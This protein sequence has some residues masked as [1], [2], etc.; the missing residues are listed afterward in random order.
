MAAA[1]RRS[2]QS[3][4]FRHLHQ[5]ARAAMTKHRRRLGTNSRSAFQCARL[6]PETRL[7]QGRF[8]PGP[9]GL[10]CPSP[11]PHMA[12]PPCPI[13]SSYKDTRQHWLGAHPTELILTECSRSEVLGVRASACGFGG[14][15]TTPTLATETPTRHQPSPRSPLPPPRDLC[16]LELMFYSWILVAPA[17][18]PTAE[19]SKQQLPRG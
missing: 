12:S 19:P 14:H 17:G 2:F 7:S 5:S 9:L 13:A 15:I 3:L 1:S 16:V 8:L 18:Y 6:A 11:C 10:S 4:L